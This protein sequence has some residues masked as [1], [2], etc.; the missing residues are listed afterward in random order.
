MRTLTQGNN[1]RVA[2]FHWKTVDLA[3]LHAVK[4]CMMF[5]LV[6]KKRINFKENPESE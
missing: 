5:S 2:Q 4:T 1:L 3:T 6:E